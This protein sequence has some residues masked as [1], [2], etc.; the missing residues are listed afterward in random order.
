MGWVGC[1]GSAG[2]VDST[3]TTIDKKLLQMPKR[4]HVEKE[5]NAKK[6]GRGRR[7]KG[8]EKG[9]SEMKTPVNRGT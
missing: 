3:M 5:E 6:E 1:G 4:E 2:L 7:E 8:E 9:R